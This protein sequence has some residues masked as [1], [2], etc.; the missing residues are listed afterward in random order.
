MDRAARGMAS[1]NRLTQPHST[2]DAGI[3]ARVEALFASG[4][5]GAQAA[6]A[7]PGPVTQHLTY[8]IHAAGASAEEVI[9][10]IE[11]KSRQAAGNGLFDRAPSTGPYGR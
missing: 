6:T 2:S 7:A 11:R 4:G 5:A 9:R 8:H 1:R 10:L 3:A